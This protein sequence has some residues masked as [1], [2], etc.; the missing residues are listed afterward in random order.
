VTLDIYSDSGRTSKID[1]LTIDDDGD[2][3]RYIYGCCSHGHPDN[4]W[5]E[6][7]VT[8]L[9]LQLPLGGY[10][11]PGRIGGGFLEMAGANLR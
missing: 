7:E 2:T 5:I 8:N 3:R 4:R 1:T 10:P 6:V 11:I 9:D